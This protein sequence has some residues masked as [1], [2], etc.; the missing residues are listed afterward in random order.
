MRLSELVTTATPWHLVLLRVA[1][2]AIQEERAEPILV[3]LLTIK[4][5]MKVSSAFDP[6]STHGCP[7][8]IRSSR[9][10]RIPVSG[11]PE[12]ERFRIALLEPTV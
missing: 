1:D 5:W 4:Q 6:A 10:H 12:P 2:T 11:A 8:C 7:R 3:L 9:Y